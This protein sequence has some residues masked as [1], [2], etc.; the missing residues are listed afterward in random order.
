M[1]PR[2]EHSPGFHLPTRG[3]P[4]GAG[5]NGQRHGVLRAAAI[6]RGAKGTTGHRDPPGPAAPQLWAPPCSSAPQHQRALGRSRAAAAGSQTRGERSRIWSSAAPARGPASSLPSFWPEARAAQRPP[7]PTAPRTHPRPGAHARRTA[8][9]RA[10]ARARAGA[11]RS[12]PGRGGVGW[13]EASSSHVTR[14]P[15]R[16]GSGQRCHC[17]VLCRARY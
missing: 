13:G 16:S 3:G 8:G 12:D 5:R 4:R 17:P 7:L 15:P 9:E 14:A 2:N 10:R 1:V 6:P 11:D